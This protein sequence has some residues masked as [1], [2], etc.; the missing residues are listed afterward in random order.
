[1]KGFAFEKKV[2]LLENAIREVQAN[3]IYRVQPYLDCQKVIVP[4]GCFVA[5]SAFDD[6]KNDVLLLPFEKGCA[7]VPEE[8]A[9]GDFQNV[10][11]TRVIDVV[12]QGTLGI[13]DTV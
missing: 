8:F 6:G 1:M 2:L 13:G 5:Q 7:E 12:A 9:A 11:V 3:A 10:E 4:R